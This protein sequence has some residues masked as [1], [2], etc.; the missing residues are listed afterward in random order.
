MIEY[1]SYTGVFEFDASIDAFHGRV[2]GLQDVVTFEGRSVEELRSEMEESVEDY[3]TLCADVGKDPERPYRGEFLV[4]STPEVHRAVATAAEDDGLSMNAWVE[5]T[6]SAV[7]DQRRVTPRPR[8][9]APKRAASKT[10][11]S[12]ATPK[13]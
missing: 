4:R 2:L 9:G 6:I 10:K 3:L 13:G 12:T 11:R 8:D 5:T 1:K 7:A